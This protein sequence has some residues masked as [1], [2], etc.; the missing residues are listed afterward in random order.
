MRTTDISGTI[1]EPLRSR[2]YHQSSN[3]EMRKSLSTLLSCNYFLMSMKIVVDPAA[4]IQISSVSIS[5][6]LG[7]LEDPLPLPF[8]HSALQI[9]FKCHQFSE[10][11][12]PPEP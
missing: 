10:S 11:N 7:E 2:S 12:L 6:A 5:M 9:L 8:L 3:P 4:Q 1:L